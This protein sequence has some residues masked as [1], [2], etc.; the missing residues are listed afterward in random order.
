M[1]ADN[2]LRCAR[3]LMRGALALLSVLSLTLSPLAVGEEIKIGGTG[4]ALGTMRLLADAFKRKHPDTQVTVLASLGTSGAL[5]AVPK[6][7][8]DIGLASRAVTGEE[9][10]AGLLST[11]YARS[12]TVFAVARKTKVASITLQQLAGIYSGT[13]AEWPDKTPIRPVLRQAGDDNTR[14]VKGLSPEIEKALDAAEKR[15]GLV[16]AVTD[17]EA[18]DKIESIPGALGVSTLAL[19]RSEARSLTPLALDGVEATPANGESGKYPLVK[20]FYFVTQSA[21]SVRVQQF[22]DFVASPDGRAILAQT[23]HW[24]P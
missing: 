10:A 9:R 11:E 8:I 4:N 22:I 16:V 2:P 14:Q 6:G 24:Q 7:A 3:P 13:F 1:P 15:A 5:K 18:A 17:Q 12:P 20:R 19:I 21:R 23:G